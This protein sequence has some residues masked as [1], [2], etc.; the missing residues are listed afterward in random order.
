MLFFF[1]L[2]AVVGT[3]LCHLFD[4]RAV[5]FTLLPLGVVLGAL[6]YA[7][8]VLEKDMRERKPAGH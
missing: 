4:E 5:W 7:D 3:V 8:L 2:G 1:L 6:L